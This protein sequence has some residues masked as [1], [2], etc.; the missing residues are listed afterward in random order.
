MIA[1]KAKAVLMTFLRKKIQQK[2]K[3]N[4]KQSVWS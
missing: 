3:Q 1:D 2:K 4:K